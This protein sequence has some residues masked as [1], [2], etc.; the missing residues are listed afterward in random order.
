MIEL[1]GREYGSRE[2]AEYF[3][4]SSCVAGTRRVMIAEGRAEG[5]RLTQVRTGTGLEFEV[6]ETRG[7]DIGRVSYRGIPISYASCGGECHPA[8]FEPFDDGW[9]RS[10]PGGLL[11][12][13]G[14]RSTGSPCIDRGEHM[15]LHGRVSNI[16]AEGT[17]VREAPDAD[18]TP[19]YEVSGHVRESKT[20]SHN[21]VLHRSVRA[22]QGESRLVI[23]DVVENQGFEDEELMLLY[24][25]NIGHP[26]VGPGAKFLT[27]SARV[28][29]R[30]ADAAEQPE[31][32]DRYVAPTPHYKDIVYYHDLE[33][34]ADCMAT[35]AIVNEEVGLGVALR[36]NK[37]ELP[38]LTQWKFLG[39]GNYVAGIEPGNAF[40]SGKAEERRLR[41]LEVLPAQAS[42]HVRIEVEVLSSKRAIASYREKNGL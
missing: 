24:H 13:G 31:A 29:P 35:A 16:P 33:A 12:M 36:F 34:N 41:G 7:M 32:Y 9:L 37:A 14:L 30:D 39:Q 6:S 11:V 25:F 5:V 40:V 20:L 27:H 10:Y 19:V 26:V 8:Y 28:T 42:K 23:E 3:G 4:D 17:C 2:L 15:P 21:L 22:R 38:R 18:G 1:C